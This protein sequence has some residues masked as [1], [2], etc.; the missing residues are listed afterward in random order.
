MGY[1]KARKDLDKLLQIHRDLE[2]VTDQDLPELKRGQSLP[3]SIPDTK[4]QACNEII[5]ISNEVAQKAESIERPGYH[6]TANDLKSIVNGIMRDINESKTHVI[7]RLCE[8]LGNYKITIHEFISSGLVDA[9]Y[10]WLTM[11]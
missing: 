11:D 1:M 5:N 4:E 2:E 10:K 6:N 8:L 3:D 7:Q 9:L